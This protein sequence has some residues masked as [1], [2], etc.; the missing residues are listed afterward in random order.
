MRRAHDAP[1]SAN[2][3]LPN[4]DRRQDRKIF[5]QYWTHQKRRAAS[6]HDCPPR[7]ASYKGNWVCRDQLGQS[8]QWAVE[9]AQLRLG[10]RSD[11]RLTREDYLDHK[12][13]WRDNRYYPT[14]WAMYV[15]S[16]NSD[17]AYNNASRPERSMHIHAVFAAPRAETPLIL[18]LR[19]DPFEGTYCSSS[20]STRSVDKDEP[21]SLGSTEKEYCKVLK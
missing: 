18:F 7:K 15:T 19:F 20:D 4:R 17:K 9:S 3:L 6:L 1:N 11:V 5:H 10:Y 2:Q 8:F 12:R 21:H 14:K 13:W 16:T